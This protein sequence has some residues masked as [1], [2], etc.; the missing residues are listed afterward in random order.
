MANDTGLVN[1]LYCLGIVE[2]KYRVCRF[3]QNNI[4]FVDEK[5]DAVKVCEKKNKTKWK[6]FGESRRFESRGSFKQGEIV[7]L[8]NDEGRPVKYFVI[9][10]DS[11]KENGINEYI[12]AR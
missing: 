1:T 5:G 8:N 2:G 10:A 9:D 4:F 3:S 11:V 12:I 6:Y 7:C